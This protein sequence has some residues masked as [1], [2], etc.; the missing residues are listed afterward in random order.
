MSSYLLDT[1]VVLWLA[2]DPEKV[3][4]KV[5][6]TLLEAE[7]L[8]VSPISAY[9]LSQN[10]HLGRLPGAQAVL[11]R[12]GE[13]LENMFASELTLTG[14]EML[15]AGSLRWDH[16]DPF[17]RMLVAQ[18]QLYGLTFVTKDAA[19]LGFSEVSCAR[20]E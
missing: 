10:A 11:A 4:F 15:Q 1:H 5:Q 16:R 8:F 17:D 6:A 20:W 9:E 7:H 19:I 13:L 2:A 12:W 3:P 14:S 18:A